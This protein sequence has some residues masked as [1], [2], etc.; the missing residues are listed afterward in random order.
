MNE[1]IS[2]NSLLYQEIKETMY[3]ATDAIRPQRTAPGSYAGC[4]SHFYS[5]QQ[6]L[7]ELLTIHNQKLFSSRVFRKK[8]KKKIQ[9]KIPVSCSTCFMNQ[10]KTRQNCHLGQ[11]LTA[12]VQTGLCCFLVNEKEE[13]REKQ[14]AEGQ[15]KYYIE[16][17]NVEIFFFFLPFLRKKILPSVRSTQISIFLSWSLVDLFHYIE[18]PIS[19]QKKSVSLFISNRTRRGKDT[20]K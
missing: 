17:L 3:T 20:N 5:S 19:K 13:T 12:I 6:L 1:R 2:N 11:Y 8:N 10:I 9:Y 18:H 4:C 15:E 16:L 7:C 14:I